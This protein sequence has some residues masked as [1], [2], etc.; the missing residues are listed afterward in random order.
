MFG[1]C[2]DVVGDGLVVAGFGRFGFARCGFDFFGL[3]DG[4]GRGKAHGQGVFVAVAAEVV[5]FAAAFG[6]LDLVGVVV[7]EVVGA[8]GQA[9]DVERGLGLVVG[10]HCFKLRVAL[11]FALVA[12]V[13]HFQAPRGFQLGGGEVKQAAAAQLAANLLQQVVGGLNAFQAAA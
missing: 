3:A 12:V 7:G 8:G 13:K 6:D 1:V 9:F 2:P 5:A 11:F 4:I 10:E